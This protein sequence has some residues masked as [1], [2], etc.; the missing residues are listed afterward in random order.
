VHVGVGFRGVDRGAQGGR[1][2]GGDGVAAL[3]VVD[4]DEGDVIVDLDQYW[5]GHGLS[6]VTGPPGERRWWC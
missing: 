5:I 2:L 3:G 6:L 4:R 1:D